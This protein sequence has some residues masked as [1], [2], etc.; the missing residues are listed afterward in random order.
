MLAVAG[1]ALLG[2]TCVLLPALPSDDVFSYVLYGRISAIHG[3]NPLVT[4]PSTFGNDP[5]LTL[6]FWR[7][8]R[9]VYGPV[10]LLLSGGLTHIAQ[11]LGG[12]LAVYIALFKLL[13]LV[14][15]LANTT[16]IWLILSRIAPSRRLLGTL[17]YAWNPLCLLEF[18]GSAHNDALMLTGVLLGVYCWVR[19]WEVPALIAFGLSIAVKYV[20]LAL[21]PFYLMLV[22]RRQLEEGGHIRQVA[23]SL[24]WRLGV[25]LGVV[26]LTSLPYWAG[27]QTLAAIAY[28]PP[29]QQL[30][31]S[32][33]EVLQW[34][35]RALAQGLGISHAA[36]A[37]IV[38]T[39]LKLAGGG[40][41]FVLWLRQL[42]TVRNRESLLAAQAW[43]LLA[44]VVVASG[45]FWPW[46]VTWMVALAAL[47]PWG[48]LSVTTL[49]LAGGALTLYAFQPLYAAGVYGLRALL[50]FGP[51]LAYLMLHRWLPRRQLIGQPP[52][53]RLGELAAPKSNGPATHS[54]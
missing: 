21:L 23:L 38:G 26:A 7:G 14:A 8:V 18:C 27:P 29:A 5:F 49:L 22:A 28:S 2:I 48:A 45:W 44:Y 12:D 46:Y 20:F 31:N 6:V 10:W 19:E 32:L 51:A 42:R 16:L 1:A 13:G 47:L 3:A 54:G 52:L 33:L 4:T 25:V 9:S 43:A 50:I 34:P 15:H 39:G 37:P 11:A 17:L 40:V 30:D 53:Q 35:L 36:A 24:S 41:F